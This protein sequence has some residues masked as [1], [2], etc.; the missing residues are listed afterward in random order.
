[1]MWVMGWAVLSLAGCGGNI[2]FGFGTGF[3]DD[4]PT[5]TV[6][7]SDTSVQA[8][9]SVRFVAAAA[10]ANGIDR[11]EFYRVDDSGSVLVETDETEPYDVTIVAPDDGRTTLRVFARAIDFADNEGESQIVSVTIT[12]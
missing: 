4:E 10:D 12:Q 9:E 11:V 3:D 5:V 6:V 7:A 2:E 1:M 8:G